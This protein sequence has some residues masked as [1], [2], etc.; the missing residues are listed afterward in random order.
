MISVRYLGQRYA[1]EDYP[2]GQGRLA[3]AMLSARYR[4]TVS[5][6]PGDPLAAITIAK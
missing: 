4:L 6:V 5:E 2:A 3:L 1:I